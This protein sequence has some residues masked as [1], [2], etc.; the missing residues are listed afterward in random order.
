MSTKVTVRRGSPDLAET[1]DRRH[2]ISPVG[3][4]RPLPQK[5][6]RNVPMSTN[7]SNQMCALGRNV[8]GELDQEIQRREDLEVPLPPDGIA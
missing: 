6:A 8:L 2:A 4:F 3:S 5:L 1:A 7:V